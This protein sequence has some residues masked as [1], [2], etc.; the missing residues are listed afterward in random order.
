MTTETPAARYEIK[1]AY[2]P[3]R[4]PELRSWIDSHPAGF[5]TAYP[6]R[7]VNSIYMDTPDL[8][9]FND[10]L[11]GIPLRRKLRFRWY[12]ED[13]AKAKGSMEVKNKSERVGWKIVQAVE[14]EFDLAGTTWDQIMNELRGNTTN[15][16]HEML[17]AARPVVLTVYFRE[18]Y[19]SGDG[20]VRLTID[21]DLRAY[22]QL[23]TAR[24]NIW[25]PQS[26]EQ[27]VIV[28]IK[29]DQENAAYISDV[30][31]HFPIRS[32]RY[33]KFLTNLSLSLVR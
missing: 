14:C 28:E 7:Q 27:A 3:G 12:G 23:M 2:E 16:V 22:D 29:S 19:V 26:L 30:L 17:C 24:P 5:A 10:H 4:L 9:S 31:S 21:T 1:M 6:P 18:Y 15:V 8:N 33:S 11:A 32:N 20:L 13:L 25:F